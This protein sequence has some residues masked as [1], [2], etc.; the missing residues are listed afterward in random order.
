[1]LTEIV[2]TSSQLLKSG[3]TFSYLV[4]LFLY[5]PPNSYCSC[6]NAYVQW[7]KWAEKHHQTLPHQPRIARFLWLGREKFIRT[8]YFNTACSPILCTIWL[9]HI[10]LIPNNLTQY[11]N[12]K[13]EK[14]ARKAMEEEQTQESN[15]RTIFCCALPWLIV[16]SS[17]II[18]IKIKVEVEDA[19]HLLIGWLLFWICL[20]F[21]VGILIWVCRSI[22]FNIGDEM[23]KDVHVETDVVRRPG[24]TT[25]RTPL[26]PS[27]PVAQ[28]V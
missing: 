22:D 21:V 12:N 25:P 5:V 19:T 28:F 26:T 8:T 20:A 11:H 9:Y 18:Y 27:T 2:L 1:M 23:G 3:S 14:L 16:F 4:I 15:W 10:L 24:C 7:G 6:M 17:G 13:T